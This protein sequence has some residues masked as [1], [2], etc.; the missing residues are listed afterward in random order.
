MNHNFKIKMLAILATISGPAIAPCFAL[1]DT[2]QVD[3]TKSNEIEIVR[4]ID[5]APSN[6]FGAI[7]AAAPVPKQSDQSLLPPIVTS[8]PSNTPDSV[9]PIFVAPPIVRGDSAYPKPVPAPQVEPQ[10]LPMPP[11]VV[12]GA[13]DAFTVPDNTP[14]SALPIPNAMPLSPLAPLVPPAELAEETP[15]ESPATTVGVPRVPSDLILMEIPASQPS[16]VDTEMES[17]VDSAPEAP[18]IET[19][20]EEIKEESVA[21]TPLDAPPTIDL[22]I[23][24]EPEVTTA[25]EVAESTELK[26]QPLPRAFDEPVID[27]ELTADDSKAKPALLPPVDTDLKKIEKIEPNTASQIA[28]NSNAGDPT[29]QNEDPPR[30]EISQAAKWNPGQASTQL[31]TAGVPLYPTAKQETAPEVK[32]TLPPIVKGESLTEPENAPKAFV[33]E[34]VQGEAQDIT[35]MVPPSE[36]VTAPVKN[37]PT[38]GQDASNPNLPAVVQGST[39]PPIAPAISPTSIPVQ[40]SK[41]LMAVAAPAPVAAPKALA[42]NEEPTNPTESLPKTLPTI[43]TSSP[44]LLQE[45]Y[46][47]I[48]ANPPAA[49]P[50]STRVA[51][52]TASTP[53]YF[54]TLPGKQ[55]SI[56][57]VVDEC[58]GC[59]GSGCPECGVMMTAEADYAG[60]Q[61]CGSGGCFDSGTVAA[62]FGNC[63]SVSSARK[64][65]IFDAIYLDRYDGTIAISNFGGLNNFENNL[66]GARVTIGRRQDAANGDEL[67]Y[68]GSANLSES[69]SHTDPLGRITVGFPSTGPFAVE[70]TAFRNA[71]EQSQSKSTMFQS[72]EYNRNDWGW[73]V[74]RT[75][76]GLRYIY[77]QDEY[78]IS[79]RNLANETGDFELS[80]R[81]NL[82]GGHLGYELFYDVG[83]RLSWSTIGKFGVYANPNR[84]KTRLNNAGAQFLDLKDTNTAFSGTIELGLNGHYK[85]GK[86]S[87]LRFGYNAFWLGEV[88]S[89]AD[90]I[91]VTINPTTGSD[92][93]DSDD[94][95]FHG[96]SLGLEIFR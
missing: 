58:L 74:V 49:I 55:S 10:V 38:V 35:E 39:L 75:F 37:A 69:A 52:Q 95:F 7:R 26:K 16:L 23:K 90:N 45:N 68:F 20:P 53:T 12:A 2:E 19:A 17:A 78:Q 3:E 30:E 27:S 41:D 13:N 5:I 70:T 57:S 89:T 93:S 6:A 42:I 21:T 86:R 64:Y 77:I 73:D 33:P 51:Q 87:R 60:C 32:N 22:P 25:P 91:P 92:T 24:A 67:S 82:L 71:T 18:A 61:S 46:K 15:N 72:L 34:I 56:E 88:A 28:D 66:F 79:S 8:E 31:S 43:P 47:A 48:T 44:A 4:P 11:I 65:F 76:V 63:G 85:L 81:N 50:A 54:N 80:T 94:M 96:L 9:P 40:P 83:Y 14:N 36:D 59:S 84:V 62:R 29:E 1:Q